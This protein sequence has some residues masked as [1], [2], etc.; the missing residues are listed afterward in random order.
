MGLPKDISIVVA[1]KAMN[2][3]LNVDLLDKDDAGNFTP[4]SGAVDTPIAAALQRLDKLDESYGLHTISHILDVMLKLC[5]DE[6]YSLAFGPNDLLDSDEIES[7][8][9]LAR[10]L[11]IATRKLS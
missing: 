10:N 3:F 4:K 1:C 5:R 6:G 9:D 11:R 2:P 8:D 7:I